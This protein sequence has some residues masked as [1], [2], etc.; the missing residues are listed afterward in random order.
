MDRPVSHITESESQSATSDNTS[1][2]GARLQSIDSA[3]NGSQRKLAQS[4]ASLK[5]EIVFKMSLPRHL[6]ESQEIRPMQVSRKRESD[7][8]STHIKVQMPGAPSQTIQA[9]SAAQ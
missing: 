4:S 8:F 2:D 1:L 3:E 5:Q 9:L 6:Y 7:T